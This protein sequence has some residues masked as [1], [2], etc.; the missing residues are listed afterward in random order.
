MWLSQIDVASTTE[1][2]LLSASNTLVAQM[3]EQARAIIK[4]AHATTLAPRIQLVE[5]LLQEMNRSLDDSHLAP[6]GVNGPV[7]ALSQWCLR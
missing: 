1:E 2:S 3:Q 7:E 6:P 4:E 5:T